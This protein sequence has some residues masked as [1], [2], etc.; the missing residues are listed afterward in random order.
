MLRRVLEVRAPGPVFD[1][2]EVGTQVVAALGM[3]GVLWGE[4]V[5][6]V[7]AE[8]LVPGEDGVLT[9]SLLDEERRRTLC[10]IKSSGPL[11]L[12]TWSPRVWTERF[13]DGYWAMSHQDRV[14][15]CKL[16]ATL[17]PVANESFDTP[18]RL[19]WQAFARGT[20][21]VIETASRVEFRTVPGLHLIQR[22]PQRPPPV[23]YPDE[24]AIFESVHGF[25]ATMPLE[26]PVARPRVLDGTGRV[27]A[28]LP[29]VAQGLVSGPSR[30]A[31]WCPVTR[32]MEF[33]W[34]SHGVVERFLLPDATHACARL[35]GDHLLVGDDLG[36]VLVF[37]ED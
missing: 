33:C 3:D 13:H 36:R 1:V 17:E 37:E 15:V 10:W 9:L 2:C 6:E 24:T 32:G 8:F 21:L 31:A 27:M 19:H 18:A 5:R 7:E 12:G 14:L 29:A 28:Q 34:S 26:N 16:G 11:D 30:V 35:Q 23:Q 4:K 22:A 25:C 20:G